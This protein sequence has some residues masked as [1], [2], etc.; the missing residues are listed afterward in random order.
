[1]V[2]I[3]YIQAATAVAFGIPLES[4]FSRLRPRRL[5]RARQVAM[6]LCRELTKR[7]LPQ[8]GAQFGGRD[9]TTILH[10]VRAVPG[11]ME[12]DPEFRDRVI[13]LRA[14]LEVREVILARAE[15]GGGDAG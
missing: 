12:S 1:M 14:G 5:A 7:S 4:M 15:L 13:A 11:F 10:A 3:P 2:T 8:I 9:H 6:Y